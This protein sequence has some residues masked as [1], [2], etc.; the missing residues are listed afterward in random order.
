[1]NLFQKIYSKRKNGASCIGFI[2]GADGPADPEREKQNNAFLEYAATKIQPNAR[3]FNEIG[4]Y[5]EKKYNAKETEID[6]FRFKTTKAQIILNHYSHLITYPKPLSENPTQKERK[7]YF[8]CDTSWEQALNYPIEKLNLDLHQFEMKT[9]SN[10]PINVRVD[11]ITE[12]IE[13]RN[14]PD[15]ITIDLLYFTGVSKEDIDTKS[16]RFQ[17]YAHH[18]KEIGQL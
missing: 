4:H 17:A 13:V 11:F 6:P 9:D 18:L 7:R 3:P 14:A 16:F 2:V 12:Y 15:D 8:E 1:M 5:L 10:E